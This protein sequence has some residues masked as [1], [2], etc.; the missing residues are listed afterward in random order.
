MGGVVISETAV[1]CSLRTDLAVT[2][3]RIFVD[4]IAG[5]SGEGIMPSPKVHIG[6]EGEGEELEQGQ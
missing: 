2:M 1:C 6:R 5:Y 4:D 3:Q